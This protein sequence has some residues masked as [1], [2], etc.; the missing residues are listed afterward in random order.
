MILTFSKSDFVQKII[1]GN[2]IHTIREDKHD[3]WKAGRMIQMWYGNPR[4]VKSKP[5]YFM[6]RQCIS[7]QKIE[8]EYQGL[9]QNGMV[10]PCIKIDGHPIYYW[11]KEDIA[12]NDGFKN[13]HEFFE[14]F[15]K[16]F[17][18]KIIHWTNK[19]YFAK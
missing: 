2:K 10:I 8:I 12:T 11:T 3:R 17:T 19:R 7:V 9:K 6:E 4:N 18:G 14:W 15:N 13:L 1:D 16:D 5:Y